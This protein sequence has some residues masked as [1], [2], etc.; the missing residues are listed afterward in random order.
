MRHSRLSSIHFA[1]KPSASIDTICLKLWTHQ[2]KTEDVDSIFINKTFRETISIKIKLSLKKFSTKT[3]TNLP[4]IFPHFGIVRVKMPH[5]FVVGFQPVSLFPFPFS[6][7]FS[8]P[9]LH[10]FYKKIIRMGP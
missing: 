6:A 2:P 1:Q 4:I 8:I 5:N 10:D 7:S 9:L 3:S